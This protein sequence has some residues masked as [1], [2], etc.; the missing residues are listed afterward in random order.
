MKK[1]I[2]GCIIAGCLFISVHAQLIVS[3]TIKDASGLPLSGVNLYW[4]EN[5]KGT[6]SDSLGQFSLAY[7]DS[8]RSAR[9]VV[10]HI[11][12]E[13]DTF[14]IS[15]GKQITI[16][17]SESRLLNTVI[18]EERIQGTSF[19]TTTVN[20]VEH[21]SKNE[22]KKAACCNLSESFETN[23]TIDVSFSDAVTGA[24]HIQLL[25]L[26][27]KYVQLTTELL[28]AIRGLAS[29]FGLSYI[30]GP[31]L[32][33]I[34]I[35][36]GAGSVVNGFEALTGQI[37]VELRKPE[38]E[39]RLHVNA[40]VNHMGRAEGNVIFTHRFKGNRWSTA[41]LAHGD[42]MNTVID[43][44]DDT[45]QDVPLIKQ[46]SF[47]HR[48]AYHGEKF[49]TQ[50]GIKGL[51]ENRGGGNMAYLRNDSL[52]PK[53]GFD[54][55]TWRGEAFWKF[56]IFFK[57]QD[58]KSIGIQAN[59]TYHDQRGFFGN[60]TYEGIQ[61]SAFLNI[62]YQSIFSNTKHKFR[63]GFTFQYDQVDEQFDTIGFQRLELIPGG[64]FE[65]TFDNL[66]NFSLVA[67]ARLDYHNLFGF[68]PVPRLNIK[69]EIVK[70]LNFRVS[71]GRGW[72][73]PNLFA[74]NTAALVSSRQINLTG[75]ELKP[76]VA[77]NYGASLHY[78]FQIGK[79]DASLVAD[80]FRTDFTN[81]LMMDREEQGSLKFYNLIGASFSHVFQFTFSFEPVKQFEIRMAYKWQDVQAVFSGT[82]QRVPLVPEHKAFINLSYTT[83]KWGF[84]F[85]FT[86]K[87]TGPSR[88]P[89]VTDPAG[90]IWQ[91]QS[92]WYPIFHAQIAKDFK[93]LEWYVGCENIGGYTQPHPI[94]D[95]QNPFGN[96]F[97]ASLIW[98]P[99]FGRMF[100]TGIRLDLEYKNAG[101]SKKQGKN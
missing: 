14:E 54:M 53:Y 60:N 61:R 39:K 81:Q 36:K 101:R 58:W 66:N 45:F 43:D 69:W 75:F 22:F 26:D 47:V 44:N 63:T 85:D 49:E 84:S 50:F 5:L 68:F 72:R 8:M 76:E 1:F 89:N 55:Q 74:E 32:E 23:A 51:Y 59:G 30:A 20:L 92:P 24:K 80:F 17:L 11:G 34:Q 7:P 94:V 87:L 64:Y 19:K 77:W 38:N 3:G 48:W 37:N 28:P 9:L 40:Y 71:G 4:A 46:G 16:T 41:L 86:A 96:D 21:L 65:Y 82:L 73:V 33:S 98:A 100:Y 35:S 83:P 70:G 93:I 13:T 97:D 12:F 15:A 31:W 95:A 52:F 29:P 88:I 67:G 57:G 42:Y 62:I 18:I 27:G 90:N 6:V 91:T 56:G 2:V 99:I 10:S 79:R 78:S 25:G